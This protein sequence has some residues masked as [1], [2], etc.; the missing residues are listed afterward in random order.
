MVQQVTVNDAQV[1]MGRNGTALV[2]SKSQPGFWHAVKLVDGVHTC[3]CV[4]FR[5]RNAC[6]HVRAVRLI[7]QGARPTAGDPSATFSLYERTLAGAFDGTPKRRETWD[8]AAID[9]GESVS[10]VEWREHR[11]LSQAS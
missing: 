5:H 2:S 7:E 10:L 9:A 8:H 4:G 3:D 11:G 6:R 1:I